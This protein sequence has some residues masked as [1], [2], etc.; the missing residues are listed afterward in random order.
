MP[1]Y[2]VADNAKLSL[3]TVLGAKLL[4]AAESETSLT[5]DEKLNVYRCKMVKKFVGFDDTILG[6]AL[7]YSCS[8]AVVGVVFYAGNDLGKHSPEKIA[9]YM[10]AEFAKNG[11]LAKVFIK[12]NPE[13]GS[14]A[15][16]IVRGGREVMNPIDPLS[17]IKN[18]EGFVANIKLVFFADKL[19][20][21]SELGKWVKSDVAY[22][23][24][25]N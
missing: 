19:I 14:S 1:A 17:A 18:I 13:H 24:V 10:E 20:T 22:I 15:S 6:N 7:E 25:I 9:A 16:F 5:A 4:K 23:P 3:D 12:P 2:A 11:I 8:A 21:S